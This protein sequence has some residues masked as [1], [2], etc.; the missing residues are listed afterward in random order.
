MNKIQKTLIICKHDAVARGLMGDIIQRFEKVGLKL[1]AMEF[2]AATEDMGNRHYPNTTEWLSKVGNR[3]L[4]EYKTKGIDAIERLGTDDAVEIGK[5]VKQWN[6]DYLSVGPVLAMVWEGPE[7]VAIGRKLVGETLPVKAAPGTI[8]GDF[9]WDNADLANA[10]MRPFYN[11]IHASGDPQ[12]A[13]EEIELWFE[14]VE[15]LDYKVYKHQ[16]MG[17]TEKMTRPDFE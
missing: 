1:V 13:L 14:G 12:E 10:Q 5:L 7:A 16:V 15:V 8:R 17:Y 11:L 2:I 6:V 9:S 3:T 4:D